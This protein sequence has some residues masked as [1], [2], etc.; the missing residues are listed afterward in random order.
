MS[1]ELF[2]NV[3]QE[4]SGIP[5]HGETV[6]GGHGLGGVRIAT[7]HKGLQI[8]VPAFCLVP[9]VQEERRWKVNR[10]AV[11]WPSKEY[12]LTISRYNPILSIP[13]SITDMA[14]YDMRALTQCAH[15]RFTVHHGGRTCKICGMELK[16]KKGGKR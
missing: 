1:D 11:I 15:T 13:S 9:G 4:V 8:N 16:D 10:V 3:L 5:G 12:T 7:R 6:Q 2:K 14:D